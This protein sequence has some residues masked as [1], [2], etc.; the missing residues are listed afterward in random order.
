MLG[1]SLAAPIG[2]INAAQIDKGIKNGFL[3]SWFIGLGSIVADMAYMMVVYM[4]FVNFIDAPIIKTFLYAF[5][6]FVLIWTG[7]ESL[8]TAG[9]VYLNENKN[10]TSLLKTFITGFLMSLSNPLT[11]LFWLGIYGSILANTASKYNN[12]QLMIYSGAILLGLVLWDI[13]MATI[14]STFRR[15][16]TSRALK[17]ISYISG[18]TLVGFGIYFGYKALS[19]L[20]F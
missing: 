19:T 18:L 4:G 2:P 6:C 20:F 12:E 1:I 10:D 16:L 11:I 5:G 8:I 3:H 14:A 13:T 15:V 9:R 17:G 7:I